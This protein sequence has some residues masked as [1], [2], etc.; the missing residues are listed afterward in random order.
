MPAAPSAGGAAVGSKALGGT[1]H[2]RNSPVSGAT[3]RTVSAPTER[4]RWPRWGHA[5]VKSGGSGS[6]S[7]VVELACDS[8]RERRRM[9]APP[10]IES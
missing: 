10:P 6:A 7:H 3:S 1:S 4:R 9:R 2:S 5:P 8:G